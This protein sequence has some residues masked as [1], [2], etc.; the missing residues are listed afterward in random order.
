MKL[1]LEI[2]AEAPSG[3]NDADA[4]VVAPQYE[5]AEIHA[6]VKGVLGLTSVELRFVSRS[7]TPVRLP[8]SRLPG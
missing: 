7:S 2:E 1:T 8:L 4:Y 5:A 6:G 3:F